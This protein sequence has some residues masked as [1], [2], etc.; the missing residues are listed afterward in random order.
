MQL[1]KPV[2]NSLTKRFNRSY[3]QEVL[4][5]YSFES[6]S[7]V[8]VLTEQW[9]EHYNEKRPR[10]ALQPKEFLKKYGKASFSIANNQLICKT[11]I[12]ANL[13]ILT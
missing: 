2:Q 8:R 9:M 1:G 10:E 5:A 11:Q 13:G 4:N 6:L 12:V 7:Q 3:R